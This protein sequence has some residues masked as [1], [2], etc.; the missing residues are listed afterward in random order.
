MKRGAST[1]IATSALG[2]RP[3]TPRQSATVMPLVNVACRLDVDRDALGDDQR[4]IDRRRDGE[5]IVHGEDARAGAF[6]HRLEIVARRIV[7]KAQQ[8]RRVRQA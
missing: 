1:S 8:R 2:G 3:Q 6:L 4:R 7:E 5:R